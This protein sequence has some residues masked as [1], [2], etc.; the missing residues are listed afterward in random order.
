M[1]RDPIIYLLEPGKPV[2]TYDA[3]TFWYEDGIRLQYQEKPLV[4]RYLSGEVDAKDLLRVT[5]DGYL[6]RST[7]V[8]ADFWP[9]LKDPVTGEECEFSETPQGYIAELLS[10]ARDTII[11]C[12]RYKIM[13]VFFNDDDMHDFTGVGANYDLYVKLR[14]HT[15]S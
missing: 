7:T 2:A 6:M 12:C 9:W 14:W 15:G 11:I 4:V 5:H 13:T 10:G 1:D 3:S 8:L